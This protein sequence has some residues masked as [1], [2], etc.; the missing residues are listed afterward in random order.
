[1]ALTNDPTLA[2]RMRRYR[3]HG[4]TNDPG[5]MQPRP[6]DEIWNYQQTDL[7][8]NYRMTDIHAALGASQM[9][10]LDDFVAK[11]HGIA[12]RYDES[13][14][15][16][17]LRTPW[18]HPNCFSSYHLYPIRLNLCEC[19]RT[20]RDIYGKLQ[21]AGI[22]VNLHYIPVYRQPYYAAMGFE[23]GYC[24]EAERYF[25]EALSIPLYPTLPVTDQEKVIRVL[26]EALA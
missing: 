7:G 21:A 24:P 5:K 11:R 18:Q 20:Q 6:G 22:G 2:E 26:R 15:D 16:L 19:G 3:S 1:M 9:T 14:A 23:P 13:L 17:P 12:Q 8:Y 10:R 4:I 25:H